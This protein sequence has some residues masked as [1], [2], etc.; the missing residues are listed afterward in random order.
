M[1]KAKMSLSHNLQGYL[2]V[3]QTSKWFIVNTEWVS[4]REVTML[5]VSE[6]SDNC[7]F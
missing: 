6:R 3:T 4:Q 2:I 5:V 1:C 7:F